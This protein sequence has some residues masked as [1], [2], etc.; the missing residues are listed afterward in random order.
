ML[1]WKC[2]V[3]SNPCREHSRIYLVL[4]KQY[5]RDYL[6]KYYSLIWD[7]CTCVGLLCNTALKDT[8]IAVKLWSMRGWMWLW[9]DKRRQPQFYLFPNIFQVYLAVIGRNLFLLRRKNLGHQSSQMLP[10]FNQIQTRASLTHQCVHCPLIKRFLAHFVKLWW[11]GV[12]QHGSMGPGPPHNSV[13]RVMVTWVT[14][15]DHGTTS[16]KQCR[17]IKQFLDGTRW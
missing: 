2:L 15:S 8:V 6:S 1:S 16:G 9:N 13:L 7:W 14:I 10:F 5:N 11:S 4:I 3:V 17:T 12:G